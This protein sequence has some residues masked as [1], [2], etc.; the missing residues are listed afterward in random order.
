M[1]SQT[2]NCSLKAVPG[3]QSNVKR[4]A[5]GVPTATHLTNLRQLCGSANMPSRVQ[6]KGPLGGLGELFAAGN[7]RL[8]LVW[9]EGCGC[10]GLG[11][12]L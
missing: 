4:C 6:L 2:C 7:G 10:V 3:P 9:A 1:W 12:G 11:F 5:K 8:V